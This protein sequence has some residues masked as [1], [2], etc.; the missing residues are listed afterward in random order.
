MELTTKQYDKTEVQ[1]TSFETKKGITEYHVIFQQTD[2]M[3]DYPTQLQNLQQ[4]YKQCVEELPGNPTAVFRRYFLNQPDCFVNGKGPFQPVLCFIHRTA[5]SHERD[6]DSSL[7]VAPE[8]SSDT[9][10]PQ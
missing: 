3:E 8:R 4:A 7:G 2:Y 9:S 5:G 1:I 10:T 6:K